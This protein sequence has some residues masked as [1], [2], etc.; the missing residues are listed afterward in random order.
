MSEGLLFAIGLTV[1]GLLVGSFLNVVIARVPAKQSI[2]TPASSCPKCGQLLRWRDNIP[3]LSWCL[4]RGRC[5]QCA[6]P[7]SVR[8]PL[9]EAANALLW[10]GLAWWAM[11][12]S[13]RISLLPLL[14]ALASAGLALAAIDLQHHRLPDAIVLPLYPLTVLGLALSQLITSQGYWIQALIGAL[15][16]GV[17]IGGLWLVTAGGGMGLGD[18]KLAPVLG[19]VTAWLGIAESIIG[20]FAAF[21]IGAIVGVVLIVSG[22][23]QRRARLAFGPFLLGGAMCAVFF[24]TPLWEL[25]AGAMGL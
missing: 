17:T 13:T 25:Y 11:G 9:I 23:S 20:L 7:I 16:W 10:L 24:G 4:L 18:A 1:L 6:E 3:L 21:L 5:R 2:A 22:R 14:L 8:Y 15:I 19:A 12:I